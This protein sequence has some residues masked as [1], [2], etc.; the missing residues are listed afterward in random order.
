MRTNYPCHIINEKLSPAKTAKTKSTMPH[1]NQ[2]KLRSSY[3]I[4]TD[5]DQNNVD[6]ENDN[7]IN[8]ALLKY[9]NNQPVG[10]SCDSSCDTARNLDPQN[11]EITTVT[12]RTMQEKLKTKTTI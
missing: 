4:T 11:S 7:K 5:L 1:P 12:N 8:I 6:N 9:T 10:Q 3:T 2:A